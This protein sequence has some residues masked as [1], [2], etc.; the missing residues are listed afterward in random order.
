[1]L[2]NVLQ[3][4]LVGQVQARGCRFVGLHDYPLCQDGEWM[5]SV[6]ASLNLLDAGLFAHT[7]WLSTDL[8]LLDAHVPWNATNRQPVFL[9]GRQSAAWNPHLY[10]LRLGG[11]L[12]DL[13]PMSLMLR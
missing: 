10:V 3:Y 1:M 9:V 13:R 7:E 8:D 6:T 5:S 4:Y 2:L 12:H 11:H